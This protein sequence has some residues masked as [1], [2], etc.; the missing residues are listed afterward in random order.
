MEVILSE[1]IETLGKAGDIVKVA[2]GYGRNYLLPRGK[3]MLADKK[4][5]QKMERH[6]Q[7]IIDRAAKVAKEYEALATRLGA[8]NL[9]C[10]VKTG[11]EGKLYGSVTSMDIADLIENAGYEVDRRKIQLSEPIK[12]LGEYDIVIK[13]HPDVKA[14]VKIKVISESESETQTT[15]NSDIEETPSAPEEVE[16]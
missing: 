9:V 3:A 12:H 7:A 8:L 6:R 5:I 14:S 1:S 11:E 4:N 16:A 10:Q 2:N 15:G 13:L